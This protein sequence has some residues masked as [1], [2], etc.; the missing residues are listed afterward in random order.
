MSLTSAGD[1]DSPRDLASRRGRKGRLFGLAS[2]MRLLF[3]ISKE[4]K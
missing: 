2:S 4:T 1:G 3:G